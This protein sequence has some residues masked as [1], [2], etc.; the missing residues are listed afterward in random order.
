MD[1]SHYLIWKKDSDGRQ[2]LSNFIHNEVLSTPILSIHKRWN[3]EY[4]NE[5]HY[6]TD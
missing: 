5:M 2:Q 6:V 1:Y 4:E 3:D